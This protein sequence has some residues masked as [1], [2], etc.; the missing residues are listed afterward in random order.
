MKKWKGKP[1]Y[2]FSFYA[3]NSNSTGT[4]EPVVEFGEGYTNRASLFVLPFLIF[5][6]YYFTT[7]NDKN[8]F[9]I[10]SISLIWFLIPDLIIFLV[11]KNTSYQIKNSFL[12][13]NYPI[14][15][16][17]TINLK[18]ITKIEIAKDGNKYKSLRINFM[19]NK[20]KNKRVTL[21]NISDYQNVISIIENGK[22]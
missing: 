18:T 7:N 19:N 9:V 13:I 14:I 16:E 3:L 2:I 10:I 22:V 17:K 4:F 1:K 12:H 21:Y 11:Q 15:K 6:M 5:L 20:K 8:Y